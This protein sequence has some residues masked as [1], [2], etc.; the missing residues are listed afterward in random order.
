[1]CKD[2]QGKPE[3]SSTQQKLYEVMQ[4]LKKQIERN[5]EESKD[6]LREGKSEI[7][8]TYWRSRRT[9][10]QYGAGT[11]SQRTGENLPEPMGKNPQI[12]ES[13]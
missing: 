8:D 11:T 6:R 3:S 13:Q 7:S 10:R 1:M 5:P 12:Q 2:T 4:I 9:E